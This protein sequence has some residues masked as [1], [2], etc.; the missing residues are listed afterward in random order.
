[1]LQEYGASVQFNT[2][3]FYKA[4]WITS[5]NKTKLDD[6]TRFKTTNVVTDKDGYLVYLAQSEWFLQTEIANNLDIKFH[7]TSEIHKNN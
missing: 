5:N 3:P 7:F 1:V 4:C 2:L 6:F